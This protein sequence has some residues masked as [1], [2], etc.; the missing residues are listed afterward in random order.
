MRK[1][2]KTALKKKLD[3]LFSEKIRSL[4]FCQKCGTTR[5]LQCA[6]IFSRKNLSIRWDEENAVCLCLKDHLY[7]AHKEPVEFSKWVS[8]FKNIPY[9]E[10]KIAH[11]KPM[12]LYDLEM[13]Y[14]QLKEC[15][16]L[17]F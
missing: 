16:Q 2:N 13:I 12:K 5:N 7:W 4:G 15:A 6:H 1:Q 3:K 9:L 17:S 11:A 8:Q 10:N 14:E